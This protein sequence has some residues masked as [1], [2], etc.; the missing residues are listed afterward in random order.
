[1]D[2]VAL[3]GGAGDDFAEEDD[4]VV[5]FADRDIA[6]GHSGAG[7]GEVGEFVVMGGE[8]GA[9]GCDVVEVL[10]H[11][12][13][14]GEPVEGRGAAADFVEDD[15]TAVGR[16]V[17]D[18]GGLV[19]LDHEGGLSARE[20]VARADTGENAVDQSDLGFSR[21]NE[22][23]G[24]GEE[25]KEGDL[26]DVG[27]FAGH[28]GAGEDDEAG[29]IGVEHGVVGNEAPGGHGLVEHRVA[30]VGD[31]DGA[32]GGEFRPDV[33]EG[34]GGF[35]QAGEGVDLGDT[36]G[37]ML[38]GGQFGENGG[39]KLAE[40]FGFEGAGAFVAAEDTAFHFLQF[41]GDKAL[42]V[43]RGL[44]SRVV[45]GDRSEVGFGHF[46]VVA[47]NGIVANLEG[48]DAGAFDFAVLQFGDPAASFG[49]GTAEFVEVRVVSRADHAAFPDGRRRFVDDGGFEKGDERVEG[50]EVGGEGE[51]RGGVVFGEG[52]AERGEK[53]K[54]G[55]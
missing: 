25:D 36:A 12:P 52:G 16:V 48:L 26:A 33:A 44:L 53:G 6:V 32:A 38:E 5:P 2:A 34:A 42:R 50:A 11:A 54:G 21:G 8:E 47:E 37:G 20:V 7:A 1:M 13:G 31:V 23:A 30:S 49:A 51:E 3:V 55:F 19:H 4:F 10:G 18:G 28:V 46:E 24:L 41:G 9:A 43:G 27:A 40:D 15:E 17:E 22:A 29:G 14:D 39:A 45:T 35:G